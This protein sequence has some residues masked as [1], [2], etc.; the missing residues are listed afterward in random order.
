MNQDLSIQLKVLSSG[1][2]KLASVQS[3]VTGVDTRVK[4]LSSSLAIYNQR[5][6]E[7]NARGNT[8]KS[9]LMAL[10]NS[11]E[12]TKNKINNLNSGLKENGES[13]EITSNR[14]DN[15]GKVLQSTGSRVN[16]LGQ[17]IMFMAGLPMLAFANSAINTAIEVER[18]WVRF[19]KV[20][21]GTEEEFQKMRVIGT[22]FSN[23]FGKDVESVNGIMAEFAKVGISDTESLKAL[24]DMTIQ[25]SML[26]DS[27][28][29]EATAGVTATMLGFSL[30]IDETREALAAIN[31]I[32]DNTASSEKGI[33]TAM[34]KTGGIAR[35]YGV[36]LREVAAMTAVMQQN[37]ITGAVA[38]N[39]LKSVMQKI[40]NV[41][42][43]AAGRMKKFGIDMQGSD[44]RTLSFTDKLALLGKKQNEIFKSGDKIRIADWNQAMSD[45]VGIFQGGR[46]SLLLEDFGKSI[47][48]NA[49]TVSTY[50][51]AMDLSADSTENLKHWNEQ[52]KKQME[53]EPFNIDKLNEVYRNQTAILGNELLPIK[54]KLLEIITGLIEKFNSLSPQTKDWIEKIAIG[55]I[56]I[57]PFLAALGLLLTTFGFIIKAIVGVTGGVLK[58]AEAMRI[59]TS[60]V[61]ASGSVGAFGAMAAFGVFLA[62][63][64]AAVQIARAIGAYKD[65]NK[66]IEENKK[67]FE[68][69]S[70]KLDEFQG[71]V[72]S[73][74]TDAANQ[75][76]QN[77]IDKAR[78]ANKAM[79][80][81]NERYAGTKGAL[82]AVGDQ[83]GVWADDLG[84]AFVKV[85]DKIDSAVK[86]IKKSV[87]GELAIK[88]ISML[89]NG[90][91]GALRAFVDS[92]KSASSASES[93]ASI[94][95]SSPGLSYA[96]GGI[97]PGSYSKPVDITAHGSEMVLNPSQQKNLF[98]MLNGRQSSN[99]GDNGTT[100]IF[101]V[102]Q[103]IASQGELRE[104]ARKIKQSMS[105]DDRRYVTS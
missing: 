77:S 46:M 73:L 33:L 88:A 59:V 79:A 19:N 55:V 23:K 101:E 22:E 41:T 3:A 76:L 57:G 8:K 45:T 62:T 25:T 43:K 47:D 13:L 102:G 72:G 90:S 38:G 81:L 78:D 39:A 17:R 34:E 83:F 28:L 6:A 61:G 36:S 85:A 103:M 11:I 71:K 52:L 67:L 66:Q 42:D 70:K 91:T 27:T 7:A 4:E 99:S 12:N 49:D 54:I 40:G 92:N 82:R 10:N 68:D 20:F 21:G 26:F 87:P 50:T 14:V 64:F 2:D 69:N 56:V 60:S 35:Q 15:F 95:L 75:Q 24:T 96:S 5:L 100:I 37:N 18:S 30:S 44:F 98:G 48:D 51:K 53:S 105:E 89:F 104:F 80:D 9:T 32:A 29:E 16:V 93:I 94:N 31:N 63:V 74:K 65:L 97:I 86:K 84:K 1:I 58:L